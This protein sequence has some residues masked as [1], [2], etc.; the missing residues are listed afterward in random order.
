MLKLC[1][2]T[3]TCAFSTARVIQRCSMGSSSWRPMRS[4][5]TVTLSEPKI[6]SRSSSRRGR[7]WNLLGLPDAQTD[8]GAG[9]RPDAIRAA[10]CPR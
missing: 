7:T 9:C 6:R 2:S 8:R 4:I 10:P 5:H 3:L 1:P